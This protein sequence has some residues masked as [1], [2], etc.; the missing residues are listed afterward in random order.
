M[1]KEVSNNKVELCVYWDSE[2]AAYKVSS[3]CVVADGDLA[4]R[5]SLEVDLSS[6]T[7]QADVDALAAAALAQVKSDEGI[8]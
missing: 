3:K 5:K 8:A 4:K 7:L 1:A 2:A 6:G